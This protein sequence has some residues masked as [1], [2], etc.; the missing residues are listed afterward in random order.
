MPRIRIRSIE[1]RTPAAATRHGKAVLK[2]KARHRMAVLRAK[3]WL[4]SAGLE[5]A[6]YQLDDQ[7]RLRIFRFKTG[8]PR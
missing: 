1:Q 5:P 8:A 4:L 3:F 7:T 2:A 6:S